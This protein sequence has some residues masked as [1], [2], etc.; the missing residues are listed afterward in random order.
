MDLCV[1]QGGRQELGTIHKHWS[2]SFSEAITDRDDFT[3]DFDPRL[4]GDERLLMLAAAL[5]IGL[6]CFERRG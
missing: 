4:S 5:F 3:V 1:R 2:G 6:M